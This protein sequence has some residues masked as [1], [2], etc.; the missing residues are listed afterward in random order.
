MEFKPYMKHLFIRLGLAALLFAQIAVAQQART[1]TVILVRHAERVSNAPDA[2]LSP[3]GQQRAECLAHVL[4]DQTEAA[5]KRTDLFERRRE[6]MDLWARFATS[7]P[8][9]VV[10]IG[11]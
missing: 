4:K 9:S 10:A 8:A 3:Q 7:I 11:A 2:L 6:L 5:Y 1:N